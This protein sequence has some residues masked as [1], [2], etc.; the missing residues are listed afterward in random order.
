MTT[1]RLVTVTPPTKRRSRR[2]QAADAPPPSIAPGPAA[3]TFGIIALVVATLYF[4]VPV[5]WLVVASTKNNTDLTSTFGFWFAEPNLAANYDSLMGWTQ[6]LFWRWVGN[7]LFYSLSA[8]IIGTLFAVMAGYAIAKFAFPG[9]KLAVGIIMAGL[10][11]P[12]AL[13]TVPL[14]IEF[15]AL[16]LTNTVWA[17]IIPSA[18]SPFGV[19]LGMVYAQSSVPTELLEAARIDG[20]GEARIFFTIVL[21]LLGPAMVTIFLFIFVATWNNFLL[22]LMMISSPDLKPVTL[23]LYG[24]MSYFSPDKG[25]VMLGALLGVIPLIALFFTLQKYWRSGLAA[26]AVKG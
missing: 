16:G 8:G 11:L 20:A 17:I 13:L 22:P 25:A 4:L 7:S 23:G 5:F 6:G 21:R 1:T 3:R 18:V 9:K 24:M 14:Y 26:G 10:L 15:Q 19:F 2:P 12:V